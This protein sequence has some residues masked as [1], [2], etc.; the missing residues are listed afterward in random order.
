MV[1]YEKRNPEILKMRKEGKSLRQLSSSFGLSV[2]RVRQ[3]ILCAEL[4]KEDESHQE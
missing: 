3:I 2:E 4:G 1:D